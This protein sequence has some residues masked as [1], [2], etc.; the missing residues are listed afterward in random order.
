MNRA[1]LFEDFPPVSTAAWEEQIREDLSGADYGEM[2]LWHLPDGFTARPYYRAEDVSPLETA[3]RKAEQKPVEVPAGWKLRQDIRTPDPDLAARHARSAVDAGVDI[4]GIDLSM[5]NG[6]CR[7]V[8]LLQSSGFD[9]FME[10]IPL[11][12]VALHLEGGAL[13]PGLFAFYVDHVREHGSA[14]AF[15]LGFDPI[16]EAARNGRRLD[17]LFDVAADMVRYVA[18][19][20]LPNARVLAARSGVYHDAGA[21]P[22]QEMALLLGSVSETFVQ[23]MARG[24]SADHVV[25]KLS[26][27]VSIGSSYFLEIA[28]LR[29]LR[30]LLRQLA[31]VYVPEKGTPL[32]PIHGE[33]SIRNRTLYDPH[34][35]LLRSTTEAASAVLGGCD[36]VVVHPFDDVAGRHD[37]FSYRM[38]RNIQH[39]LRF[40]AGFDRVA[41]PAAGSY[42]VEVLTDALARRAW[43]LFQDIESRGGLLKALESGFV[44]EQIEASAAECRKAVAERRTILV[45]T[46]HYPDPDERR[47]GDVAENAG[48]AVAN[49]EGSTGA[50]STCEEVRR[51]IVSGSG[52][53]EIWSLTDGAAIAD[54]LRAE[55]LAEPVERRR[56][57]TE[58]GGRELRILIA[59]F[60]D[61]AIRSARSHFAATFLGCGGFPTDS[62]LAFKN[63]DDITRTVRDIHPAVVVYCAD[64]HAYPD[65]LVEVHHQLASVEGI[66]LRGI[67]AQPEVSGQLDER[68]FDFAIHRGSNLL[69]VLDDLHRRL[70][71]GSETPEQSEISGGKGRAEA[72]APFEAPEPPAAS[73]KPRT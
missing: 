61:P 5:S 32:P 18:D 24:V 22:P 13:S 39:M 7:G 69:D 33:T 11:S 68:W 47:M 23:M 25:D 57:R 70:G 52:L 15:S 28:R 73:D 40:E 67:V 31:D 72:S 59:P 60:G 30:I 19:E 14:A 53:R 4:L 20:E 2:L 27:R 21:T 50:P 29:A 38:A 64:D 8:P 65:L 44:H 42:Y 49:V 51:R 26:I 58:R 36:V 35:N 1:H 37:E 56:L 55:R 41:D 66:I 3:V 48:I 71:I 43:H 16:G 45:G 17:R 63:A 62:P 10:G 6:R 46:N 34:E 9:A 54:P 12:D